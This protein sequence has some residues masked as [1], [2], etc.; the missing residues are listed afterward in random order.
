MR[1]DAHP[2][3]PRDPELTRSARRAAVAAAGLLLA[4]LASGGAAS[5][6][7]P[8]LVGALIALIRYTPARV[9]LAVPLLV[10]AV[11]VSHAVIFDALGGRVVLAALGAGVATV[12]G[13]VWRR[14]ARRTAESLAKLDDIMAQARRD[15][16]AAV[17]AAAEELADLQRALASVA[18]RIGAHSVLL[19]DVEGYRGAARP[20]AGSANRP[21][22]PVRLS[23]DPLGWAWEQGMRLRMEDA[24][25]WAEP[26]NAVVIDRLR[27]HDDVGHLVTYAFEP[28]RMPADELPFEEAAV[29]LR[30]VMAL[31]D[32]RADANEDSRRLNT[33]L[34]GVRRIPGELDLETLAPDLC[35]TAASLVNGSGAAI[36]LWNGDHGSVVAVSG[37]DGGPRPGDLFG[38]PASELALA[39]RAEAMLVR[40][41]PEW[42][43]GRTCVAHPHERWQTRPRALAALPLR[44]PVGTI[45]VLAVWTTKAS[46]L[47]PDALALLH[48][49]S[50]YAAMHL[51]HAR[52][53][54]SMRESAERDPLTQLRNRL[55]F[56]QIFTAEATRFERYGRP[57][58]LLMLD[59][60][61]FKG[62]NDQYGHEAGDEILRRTARTI[63]S[64]IRDVDTAARLGGEE[65]VV[66][67]PETP[68]AA[69][70]DAGERIRQAITRAPIEWRGSSIPVRISIGVSSAPER[71]ATPAELIGSADAALYQAKETG[72]NRVVAAE[73]VR[74]R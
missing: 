63:E 40:Q 12:A 34:A 32:A 68:L 50:P 54:G 20:L 15:R 49:L 1:S 16:S 69:A 7:V 39:V 25:R 11:L 72:R 62:I 64:C 74:A 61:H 52:T 19:W 13:L 30:G 43:L 4:S 18:G 41:A 59:L 14:E 29:Y 53:F 33:L 31:Q 60:D 2:P 70:V 22:V 46:A 3:A 67:M 27:R 51:E 58:S 57:I 47:E 5:P 8:L 26:G 35:Q 42:S 73:A 38:P 10:F 37:D 44:G 9:V 66:L 71:V 65:F 24:P 36:G 21:P 45:G 17:P 55:A 28:G 48:A 56:D 23:G 6:L